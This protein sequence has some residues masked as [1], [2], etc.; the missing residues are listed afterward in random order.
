ML[1]GWG[2]SK[3]KFWI[4]ALLIGILGSPKALWSATEKDPYRRSKLT[5]DRS[6]GQADRRSL[7][8]ATGEDKVVDLDFEANVTANG[9]A[10]GNPK[11]VLTTLVR[12]GE[13]RQLVF[14]PLADGR[15]T[16][17]VRDEEG[18]VRLI[19]AVNVTGSNLLTNKREIMDL[20]KDIEGIDIRIVGKKIIIDGEV[21]VPSDYGRILNVTDPNYTDLV[22]NLVTLSPIAMRALAQRIQK[23]VSVFAP[24]V[25][26]RVVNG[27]IWLEG[28]AD[29]IDVA[30]RAERVADLYFPEAKPGEPIERKDPSL[31]R[32]PPRSPVQNFIV[33]NPPPPQKQEKLV[34]V[35]VHFVELQKDYGK[36]FGFKWQP[37]F[38]ADPTIQIGTT[39]AGAAGSSEGFNFTATISSL[40][41]R[42]QSAQSAGYARILKTGTIMVRSGKPAKL[43]DQ[44]DIPFTQTASNGQVVSSTAGVGLLLSVTPL[45]LGESEDI[46][47]DLILEQSNLGPKASGG[48]PTTS[49]HRVET[50]LYVQ[51]KESAAVAGLDS[52]DV[53]TNFNKDDPNATASNSPNTS[54]L[55]TLLRSKSFDKK[56]AQFVIF[57]T[58]QIIESASQGTEDL[59]RNFRVKVD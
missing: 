5:S 41:P 29:S 30:K 19:F 4:A 35:T 23:D 56:K 51:N 27:A 7:L 10:I 2:L 1:T 59:K 11:V 28:T 17:T 38:T 57:V 14:K 20:T 16:V 9:I 18:N 54:P 43:A 53:Q 32:R 34:R 15:T 8:M 42:L 3:T 55:F 40:F 6:E 24:N 50:K 47:M 45:I 36:F 12:V 48:V 52:Q 21:L 31:K 22:I 58:P 37:G 26:T 13:K 33:I 49:T 25:S 44:T 46:E 39:A